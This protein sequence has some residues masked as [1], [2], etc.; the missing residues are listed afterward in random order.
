MVNQNV[1]PPTTEV[2]AQDV[3]RDAGSYTVDSKAFPNVDNGYVKTNTNHF[4]Y[5]LHETVTNFL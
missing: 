3:D 5:L 4:K 2:V 1:Y